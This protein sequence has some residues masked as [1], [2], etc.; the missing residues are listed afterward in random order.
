MAHFFELQYNET[1]EYERRMETRM[2]TYT[3]SKAGR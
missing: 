2:D 1:R 3:H